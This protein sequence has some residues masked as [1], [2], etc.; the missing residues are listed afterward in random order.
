MASS[1]LEGQ[2]YALTSQFSK[3]K[4][5]SMV[6]VKLTDSA[7]KAIEDY[8]AALSKVCVTAV[9]S[10]FLST[11][12]FFS[13]E[14]HLELFD[15]AVCSFVANYPIIFLRLSVCL[16]V[17]VGDHRSVCSSPL[18]CFRPSLSKV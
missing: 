5:Q 12:L 3:I 10:F 11:F 9:L 17:S 2:Q 1:I 6:F 4:G 13:R 8:A 14:P 7:L 18:L 16:S 15:C